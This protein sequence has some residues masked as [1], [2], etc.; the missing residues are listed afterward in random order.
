MLQSKAKFPW[1]RF[2]RKPEQPPSSYWDEYLWEKDLEAFPRPKDTEP[3]QPPSSVA[4]TDLPLPTVPAIT[5]A[6]S[7]LDESRG[8]PIFL[9]RGTLVP[10]EIHSE[11]TTSTLNVRNPSRTKLRVRPDP[12][13]I[14]GAGRQGMLGP[15]GEQLEERRRQDLAGFTPARRSYLEIP[16]PMPTLATDRPPFPP[17]GLGS[18]HVRSH[19]DVGYNGR[20]TTPDRCGARPR[21]RSD[22][23]AQP[24]EADASG[25]RLSRTSPAPALSP[26]ATESTS[27][28]TS[29]PLTTAPTRRRMSRREL[30]L[31][32]HQTQEAVAA[33]EGLL[34]VSTIDIPPLTSH[35]RFFS[36]TNNG[37]INTDHLHAEIEILRREV[38]RLQNLLLTPRRHAIS[39]DTNSFGGNEDNEPNPPPVYST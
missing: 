12:M 37:N 24:A 32:L 2:G 16:P 29:S 4:Y 31:S 22:G 21:S 34:S 1:F 11:S 5:R 39:G 26:I 20:L 27:L 30:T 25:R 9:P 15:S 13:L 23:G 19:S 6:S 33:L 10:S 8:A 18:S 14:Q 35:S 3:R 17:P 38:R 36:S 28:P 7:H